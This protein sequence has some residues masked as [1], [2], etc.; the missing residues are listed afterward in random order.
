MFGS[1]ALTNSSVHGCLRESFVRA[2][3]F[4]IP[5]STA[6]PRSPGTQP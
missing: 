3:G 1:L 6:G 2:G 5:V 4:A